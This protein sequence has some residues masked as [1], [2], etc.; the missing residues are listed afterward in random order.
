M[1]ARREAHDGQRAIDRPAC[2]VARMT[3]IALRVL[4]RHVSPRC[5]P[6]T[7]ACRRA[8]TPVSAHS[9]ARRTQRPVLY[10]HELIAAADDEHGLGRW[11]LRGRSAARETQR[12]RRRAATRLATSRARTHRLVAPLATANPFRRIPRARVGERR[13]RRREPGRIGSR[14]APQTRC[15]DL[16][17]ERFAARHVTRAPAGVG[18]LHRRRPRVGQR[19]HSCSRAIWCTPSLPR[20][21]RIPPSGSASTAVVHERGHG[22]TRGHAP[23]VPL[24]NLRTWIEI[25]T[26]EQLP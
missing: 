18:S 5:H 13:R 24:A 11:A 21:A 23:F 4:Q 12:W 22:R 19:S 1:S 7:E 20:S 15:C 6:S 14:R 9:G 3:R 10:R 2:G 16:L 8:R 25:V 17:Q 26:P